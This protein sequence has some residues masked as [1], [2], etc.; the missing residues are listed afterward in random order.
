[1]L[2]AES[3]SPPSRARLFSVALSSARSRVRLA[4]CWVRLARVPGLP[5]KSPSGLPLARPKP[6][7]DNEL[8]R[9]S[10]FVSGDC[11]VARPDRLTPPPPRTA[12]VGPTSVGPNS[13]KEF[14]FGPTEVGP[15]LEDP[16]S[17]LSTSGRGNP[18]AL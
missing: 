9:C 11:L 18:R 1:M 5:R 14:D 10:G 17:H 12:S 8:C 16:P 13:R 3:S 6:E 2:T 7:Y 4:R 15:T